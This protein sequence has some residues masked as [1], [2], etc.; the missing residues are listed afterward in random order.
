MALELCEGR[1]RDT[2]IKLTPVYEGRFEIYI[3]GEKVFDRKEAGTSD[4]LPFHG[5]AGKAKEA[6]TNALNA[7][8]PA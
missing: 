3:H 2:D 1:V 5:T 6:L 8:A 7:P 4:F